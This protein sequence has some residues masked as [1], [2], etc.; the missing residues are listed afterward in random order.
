[1]N[2]LRLAHERKHSSRQYAIAPATGVGRAADGAWSGDGRIKLTNRSGSGDIERVE[3]CC[4]LS[5]SLH[6]HPPLPPRPRRRPPKMS[7]DESH[8]HNFEQVRTPIR[9]SANPRLTF[10]AP[11]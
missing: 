6:L 3:L 4:S 7:D 8:Q 11:T 1:M 10:F 2:K 5:P 9:P